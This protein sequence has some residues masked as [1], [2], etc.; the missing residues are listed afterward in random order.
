MMLT[1]HN[2]KEYDLHRNLVVSL[3]EQIVESE[4]SLSALRL[5]PKRSIRNA[6][7]SQTMTKKAMYDRKNCQ[8]LTDTSEKK[9]TVQ[10]R[11]NNSWHS[12]FIDHHKYHISQQS[13]KMV[14]SS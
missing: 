8:N 12:E 9:A 4:K 3:K 6:V 11:D 10:L 1:D 2:L 7:F 5:D 13:S 14:L